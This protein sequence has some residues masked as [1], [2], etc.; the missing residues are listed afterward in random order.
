MSHDD[1]GDIDPRLAEALAVGDEAA[2][3]QVMLDVRLLVPMVPVGQDSRAVDMAVPALIG[4]DGRQALPVFSSYST[5]RSWRADAR[6]VP[7]SGH[8]AVSAAASEGY[9]AVVL[10][11]AGPHPQVVEIRPQRAAEPPAPPRC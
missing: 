3:R 2:I 10:D 4:A 5:L 8:Q 1:N 9:A 6:P 7:M 11:V